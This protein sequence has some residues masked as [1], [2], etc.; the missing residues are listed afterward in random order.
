M[1]LPIH[2]NP[3]SGV[4]CY[5]LVADAGRGQSEQAMPCG[6]SA[7]TA[8]PA[9]HATPTPYYSDSLVTL[10]HGDCAELLPQL[11][12]W[13]AVITDPPYLTGEAEVPIR[14]KG[15]A[16]RIE[17][18]KTV[19]MPWGYSLEWIGLCGAPLHWIVFAHYKMLGGVCSALPP[20]TVFVWR[21]VNAPN[22][23]RPVPRLDCEFIVWSRNAKAGC[24]RMGEF[25]SMVIDLP[26]PQA[27][28]MANE[29]L[30]ID[31]GKAAHPCQKPLGIV[32]PFID[33]LDFDCALDPF[34]GTGTTLLAA[35]LIGRRAIGIE[36]EERYC[37]M[38]ANRFA[39]E[40][41]LFGENVAGARGG[42]AGSARADQ[43]ELLTGQRSATFP[44][45]SASRGDL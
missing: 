30:V 40:T 9:G 23:T 16:K 41:F 20:S 28:C 42:S 27:G 18:T 26:M 44:V 34:A 3:A 36:R 32:A 8:W 35:K 22:M 45:V 17:E 43:P 1:T 33:R 37:E 13:D 11:S 25:K 21:K 2:D 31:G 29:R 4:L 19:G 15:V 12:G 38:A 14:G 7:G 6:G 5:E 10:Y 24:G 39:Q